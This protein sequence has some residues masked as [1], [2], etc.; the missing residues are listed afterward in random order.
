MWTAGLRL[1]DGMWWALKSGNH[2]SV[3][4][5]R[6]ILEWTRSTSSGVAKSTSPVCIGF[7]SLP[8]P[9]SVTGLAAMEEGVVELAGS[10]AG[11]VRGCGIHE[12]ILHRRTPCPCL[13]RAEATGCSWHWVQARCCWPDA[14]QRRLVRWGGHL[15][16][17]SKMLENAVRVGRAE[18]TATARAPVPQRGEHSWCLPA[19]RL[20]SS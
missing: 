13:A 20:R 14:S 7:R 6:K 3:A 9:I 4:S 12:R 5:M 19:W 10:G 17:A 16:Q 8:G 2:Q 11:G 18:S 15:P 1:W